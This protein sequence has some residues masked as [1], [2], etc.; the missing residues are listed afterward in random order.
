[1]ENVYIFLKLLI[2]LSLSSTLRAAG[3][4]SSSNKCLRATQKNVDKI[5]NVHFALINKNNTFRE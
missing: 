5:N 2:V 3:Q 4:E 1:M